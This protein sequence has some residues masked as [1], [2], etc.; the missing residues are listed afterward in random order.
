MA[1]FITQVSV[2]AGDREVPQS[3]IRR[4]VT[5][6]GVLSTS[7]VYQ[8]HRVLVHGLLTL[9]VSNFLRYTMNCESVM[10]KV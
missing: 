7:G 10:S 1:V 8:C 9:R 6:Y 2:V 3:T 5:F 4:S